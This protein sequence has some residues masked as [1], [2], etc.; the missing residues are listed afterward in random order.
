M[1]SFAL[2]LLKMYVLLLAGLF[3][4]F[5]LIGN[6][7]DYGS[8]EQFVKH[9]L[10]MD[11]TFED[12]ALMWRAI[13]NPVM[14]TIGYWLLIVAEA[15]FSFLA[16]FGAYQL[17]KHRK[18]SGTVFNAAKKF[19]FYAFIV[20]FSIWFLGFIVIGSEWFA[21]WQSPIWNGK[22]TAMDI[23]E[24]WIGFAILLALKDGDLQ[25]E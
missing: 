11:T 24:V 9:V 18:A 25:V 2:R 3:G 13:T 17:F 15:L 8:N 22:Q 14:H 7:M 20:G 21:M 16:I 10:S 23:T 19:G 4:I 1:N 12:N 6:L 5:V